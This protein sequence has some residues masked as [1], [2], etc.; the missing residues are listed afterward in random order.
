MVLIIPKL[1]LLLEYVREDEINVDEHTV[2]FDS[3]GDYI[4]QAIPKVKVVHYGKTQFR[5]TKH[6]N[7]DPN[8][9]RRSYEE[10]E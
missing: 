5:S 6:S 10:L 7:P 8:L 1:K 4:T 9:G 3:H 2:V